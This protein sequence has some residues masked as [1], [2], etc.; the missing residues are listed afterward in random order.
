MLDVVRFDNFAGGLDL[1]TS[2]QDLEDGYTQFAENFRAGGASLVGAL[3]DEWTSSPSNVSAI[4]FTTGVGSVGYWANLLDGFAAVKGDGTLL[5][6]IVARQGAWEKLTLANANTIVGTT[7]TAIRSGMSTGSEMIPSFAMHNNKLYGLDPLNNIGVWDGTTLTTAAPGVNTG[8]P[9][10]IILG[11][12]AARMW[13]AVANG[14]GGLGLTIQFSEPFDSTNGFI[15]A[16]GLWP[17]SNTLTLGGSAASSEN[18]V[19]GFPTPDGLAV[20]TT[21]GL[22]LVY[23]DETGANTL[24]DVNGGS[25]ARRALVQ[26]S[27]GMIYGVNQRGIF[28]TNGRL[29]VE[30]VSNRIEP[31]FT[32]NAQMGD[33]EMASRCA[34]VIYDGSYFVSY[35]TWRNSGN[36]E[37]R[38]GIEVDLETGALALHTCGVGDANFYLLVPMHQLAGGSTTQPM[39]FVARRATKVGAGGGS[40]PPASDGARYMHRTLCSSGTYRATDAVSILGGSTP[41]LASQGYY[42]H[43]LP[44]VARGQMIRAR[45]VRL[46]ARGDF[47]VAIGKDWQPPRFSFAYSGTNDWG[48]AAESSFDWEHPLNWSGNGVGYPQ[49]LL[50]SGRARPKG[51]RGDALGCV[52]R[53]PEPTFGSYYTGGEPMVEA[54]DLGLMVSSRRYT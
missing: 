17:A 53:A 50:S 23:D 2:L 42:K 48:A 28:R 37:R 49:M 3:R 19:A 31:L 43:A 1:A 18:I 27:D 13:V 32:K 16:T 10:G 51:V 21:G 7:R 40:D 29:P 24:V 45:D 54:L 44:Y 26:H 46:M 20:F 25:S 14:S 5:G 33:N 4:D 22:Y 30:Y 9:K 38:W 34:G 39:L 8:P 47:T 15:N 11:I 35:T 6:L 12:W 41:L 52:L 36:D